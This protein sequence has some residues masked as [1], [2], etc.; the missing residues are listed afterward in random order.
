[1]KACETA[2][3]MPYIAMGRER[4]H[5]PVE[6]PWTEPP[7]LSPDANSVDA[8]AHRLSTIEGRAVYAQR[9]STVEPVFGIVKSVLGFR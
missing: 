5:P 2:G 4:H 8:M 3:V 9:K 7:P 1:M 6:Q